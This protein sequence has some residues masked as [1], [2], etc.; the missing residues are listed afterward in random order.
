MNR[1]KTE[2]YETDRRNKR[3]Q[4]QISDLL[5]PVTSNKMML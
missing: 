4:N 5:P 3:T 2:E 1:K